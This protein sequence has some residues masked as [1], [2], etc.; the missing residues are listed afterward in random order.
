VLSAKCKVKIQALRSI[1]NIHGLILLGN[2]RAEH[3]WLVAGGPSRQLNILSSQTGNVAS[4]RF[5]EP[6]G[7]GL[8][9]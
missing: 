1:V 9:G 3:F 5:G 4:D 2:Y 6:I 7:N 8:A